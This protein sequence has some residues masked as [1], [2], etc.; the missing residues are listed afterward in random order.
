MPLAREERTRRKQTISNF[1]S[2]LIMQACSYRS[3][4][5]V[6]KVP[7]FA[8]SQDC[9]V[10][11]FPFITIRT[12]TTAEWVVHQTHDEFLDFFPGSNSKQSFNTCYAQEC[13]ISLTRK[14]K[15]HEGISS[16]SQANTL[17]IQNTHS[18]PLSLGPWNIVTE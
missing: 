18:F 7:V 8:G 11:P 2:E 14:P 3:V 1:I 4:N 17:T 10:Q 5:I 15:V 13:I 12:L 16:N 6:R 9:T